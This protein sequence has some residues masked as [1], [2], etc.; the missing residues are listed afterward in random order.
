MLYIKLFIEREKIQV[1]LCR[2]VPLNCYYFKPGRAYRW[3]N[4]LTTT[5]CTCR[6]FASKDLVQ[7][8]SLPVTLTMCGSWALKSTTLAQ[9]GDL[10]R[11]LH[12]MGEYRFQRFGTLIAL[13][14][15]RCVARSEQVFEVMSLC[16][17]A[18]KQPSFHWF[19]LSWGI[20][21]QVNASVCF[22]GMLLITKCGKIKTFVDEL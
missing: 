21:S 6:R 9:P 13:K 18:C 22:N 17:Y 20:R 2:S 10:T 1:N 7:N 19:M 16:L 12:F 3:E 8:L 11:H 4:C 5:N 15:A 14:R